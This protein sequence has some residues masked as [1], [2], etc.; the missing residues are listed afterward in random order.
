MT[1]VELLV[2]IVVSGL[3]MGL[4]V[5][6]FVNGLTAQQNATARDRATGQANVLSASLTSSIRNATATRVAADGARVDATVFT[7]TGAWECRAWALS[8]GRILFSSGSTARAASTTG[9]TALAS[10]AE[11]TLSGDAPFAAEGDRTVA[12]GIRITD[13]KQVAVISNGVTAQAVAT[14][15]APTC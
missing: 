1:L 13:E 5:V 6:A 4:L 15:G 2:A 10:G 12:I 3:L 7:D 11:G 9:W 8:A 14:G